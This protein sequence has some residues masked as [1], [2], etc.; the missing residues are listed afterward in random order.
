MAKMITAT[1]MS[2]QK[3]RCLQRV[4]Q[5]AQRPKKARVLLLKVVGGK[6]LVTTVM[7]T[8]CRSQKE[9]FTPSFT[10]N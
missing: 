1:A 5:A 7:K 3:Q 6:E 4:M 9:M 2:N 10:G 8:K